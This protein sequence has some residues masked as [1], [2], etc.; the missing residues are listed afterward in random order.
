MT[1]P[2]RQS[3][4]TKLVSKENL[5]QSTGADVAQRR[6]DSKQEVRVPYYT[7]HSRQNAEGGQAQ[8]L[9]GELQPNGVVKTFETVSV[10]ILQKSR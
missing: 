1:L 10:E 8:R 4:T 2:E 6:N 9:C 3:H 7:M 5:G